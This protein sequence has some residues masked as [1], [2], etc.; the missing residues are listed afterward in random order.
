MTKAF[1]WQQVIRIL[2]VLLIIEAL[3]MSFTAIVSYIYKGSDL[4]AII[5]STIITASAGV[6]G[7]LVG[8]KNT[9]HFGTREGYLVVGLVWIVFSIFGM[10]P[11]G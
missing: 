4:M 9:K 7:I 8:G 10:L 1:N 3:F 11:L 6:G 2:G 5:D